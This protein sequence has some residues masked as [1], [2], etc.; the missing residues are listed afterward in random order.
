MGQIIIMNILT[1]PPHALQVF[2][3]GQNC[4]QYYKSLARKKNEAEK[5]HKKIF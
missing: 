1:L 2:K 4:K 5:Y 3:R